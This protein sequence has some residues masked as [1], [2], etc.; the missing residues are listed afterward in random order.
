MAKWCTIAPILY[1]DIEKKI[2]LPFELGNG[3]HLI[4]LPDW[5]K[6]DTMTEYLNYNKRDQLINYANYAIE[7][8]YDAN[9]YGEPDPDW[10]GKDPRSLQNRA[11]EF[12]HL[13]NIAIWISNPCDFRYELI[14]NVYEQNEKWNFKAYSEYIGLK[15]HK[16]YMNYK[17]NMQDLLLAKNL[18]DV[19]TK[20]QRQSPV[21][22][23]IR[24]LWRALTE[25]TW[26]VRFLLMW[27]ALEGLFGPDDP[28]EIT[29]RLSQRLALFL[30]SE[31]KKN[32]KPLYDV[33]K[34][35]YGWR[36]KVVHGMRLNNLPEDDSDDILYNAEKWIRLSLVKIL[37]DPKLLTMFNEN[38]ETYL[39]NIIFE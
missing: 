3:V 37:S 30:S 1:S 31:D 25:D 19:L 5:L 27:I 23:A 39:D 20:I 32:A 21:W 4:P 8:T 18:L 14:Y 29:Y 17:L 7:V 10:K 13:C 12:I 34:K 22:V 38:R 36:S 6:E 24:S 9:S 26:E 16:K 35:A 33:I 15:P 2:A 11:V 28:K